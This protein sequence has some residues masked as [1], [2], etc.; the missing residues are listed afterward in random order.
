L[1]FDTNNGRQVNQTGLS[2]PAGNLLL[3]KPDAIGNEVALLVKR[4]V[5]K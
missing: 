1:W 5:A 3:S 4:V 2:I